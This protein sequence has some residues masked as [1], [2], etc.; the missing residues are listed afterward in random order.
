MSGAVDAPRLKMNRLTLLALFGIFALPPL[1]GWF[2]MLNPQWLPNESINN[3]TLI[4]PPRPLSGLTLK[5]ADDQVLDWQQLRDKW[6]F[7]LVNRG[8]CGEACLARLVD[9][10]QLRRALAAE[11]RRVE[12]ML[13]QLPDASGTV[14][15]PPSAA[16]L[17]GTLLLQPVDARAVDL[18][19]AL[20]QLEGLEPTHQMFLIDPHGDLMM[21]HDLL[22]LQPKQILKDLE[23]LMKASANWVTGEN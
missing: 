22:A 15:T 18:V 17:E 16:G 5:F 1:L 3:G 23:L 20:F 6:V 12:R 9:L 7:V 4:H 19:R 8:E 14:P 11:S 2:F 13:I 10:R 21:R